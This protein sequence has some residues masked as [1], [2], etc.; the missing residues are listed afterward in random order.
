MKKYLTKDACKYTLAKIVPINYECESLLGPPS[1]SLSLDFFLPGSR[2]IS[3][4]SRPSVTYLMR[5]CGLE[6]R[7]G[8]ESWH[9]EASDDLGWKS[10][11]DL[12]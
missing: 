6:I 10:A 4:S 1:S 3:M 9:L 2:R 7:A 12:N 8:Q 5:V 11:I